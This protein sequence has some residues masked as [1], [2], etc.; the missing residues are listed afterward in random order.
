[1]LKL[2]VMTSQEE[3]FWV[4]TCVVIPTLPANRTLKVIFVIFSVD[5]GDEILAGHTLNYNDVQVKYL[6]K[7]KTHSKTFCLFVQ[8][9]V[10]Q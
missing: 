7:L 6:D 2:P 5:I 9:K 8:D 10:R 3:F 4:V 1:M